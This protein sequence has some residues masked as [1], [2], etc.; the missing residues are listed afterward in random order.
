MCELAG[1]SKATYYRAHDPQEAFLKKYQHLQAAIKQIIKKNSHYGIRRIKA[2]LYQTHKICVGRDALGKLLKLWRLSLPRKIK[3]NKRSVLQEILLLLAGKANVLIRANIT[4]PFQAITS[5]ITKLS[6]DNGRKFAYLCVHKDIYGQMVY[7]WALA[8]NMEK[9]LVL[10][11]FKMAKNRIEKLISKLPEDIIWH[12]D[13]GSQYTSYDY[14]DAVTEA[15]VISYSNK[16]TPTH[17]AGQESFFGRFKDEWADEIQE[18]QTK[19]ELEKFIKN[20]INYYNNK[21]LHTSIGNISPNA[22]TKKFLK[23]SSK[24]FSNLRT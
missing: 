2:E 6:Y 11:S 14:V 12:Q 9:I 19:N 22:F 7:G 13:Q 10:K 8:A 16:G 17:N 20:K 18:I 24:W 5:D 3:K 4:E 15:G 21:R 1:I 23:K